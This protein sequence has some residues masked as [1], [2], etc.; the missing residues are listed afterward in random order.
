MKNI[1]RTAGCLLLSLMLAAA[2]VPRAVRAT[3]PQDGAQ[4]QDSVQGTE[5]KDPYQQQ[6]EDTYKQEVQTNKLK[7]PG[8]RHLRRCGD[9]DGCGDRGCLIWKEY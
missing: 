3:A 9:R 5:A 6:L 1:I 8:S 4:S 2:A 7:A